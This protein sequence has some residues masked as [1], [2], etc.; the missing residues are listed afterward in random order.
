M[1]EKSLVA[2][3][4]QSGGDNYAIRNKGD[5]SNSNAVLRELTGEK[6]N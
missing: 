1:D 2:N 5:N 6:S 4:S 3:S